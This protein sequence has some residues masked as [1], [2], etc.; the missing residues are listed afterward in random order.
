ME[1]CT[2]SAALADLS[3]IEMGWVVDPAQPGYVHPLKQSPEKSHQ[4]D[5]RL[6]ADLV[7]VDYLPKV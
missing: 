2:G 3:V 7:R 5:A 4:G 1:V 6:L